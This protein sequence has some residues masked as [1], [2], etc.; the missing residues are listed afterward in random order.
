[1]DVY[2]LFGYGG[3]CWWFWF[4]QFDLVG[5]DGVGLVGVGQFGEWFVVWVGEVEC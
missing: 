2:F 5:D 4:W 3:Y 1:M